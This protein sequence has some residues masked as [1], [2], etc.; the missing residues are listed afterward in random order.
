MTPFL[1]HICSFP[2]I[3]RE[4]GMVA[5]VINP[6]VIVLASLRTT[7]RVQFPYRFDI[8]DNIGEAIHIHYK[9]NIRIDLTTA[10]FTKLA[11]AMGD[12]IDAIVDVEG[13]SS[14]DFDPVALVGLSGSL[15]HLEK[16][17]YVSM[18]LADIQVDTF[19]PD[20]NPILAGLP[21]SRVVKALNG[22]TAE[23]DAHTVQLNHIRFGDTERMTNQER[24]LFN[25]ERV[26][27]Y[28]YP[29]GGDYI[30]ID[31]RNRI[32]D[33]QHRAACLYYLF[34][35]IEVMVRRIYFGK[36]KEE[37]SR[38]WQRESEYE[39]YIKEKEERMRQ[40]A[41]SRNRSWRQR[42]WNLISRYGWATWNKTE[43]DRHEYVER[44]THIEEKLERLE[45][46]LD[47]R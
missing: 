26:K 17:E 29:A 41:E 31:S 24:V 36:T 13:F 10:E 37:M 45:Q 14:R 47:S 33:G 32:C 3:D 9:D 7:E 8:E 30:T 28:G 11:E 39:L 46:K 25:L 12:I 1:R 20:G 5:D 6:G 22:I 18:P 16:I 21:Q 42:L 15:P 40:E 19:D 44:L 2:I 38:D 27:R 43:Y 4:K 34:G 35:N 23:N